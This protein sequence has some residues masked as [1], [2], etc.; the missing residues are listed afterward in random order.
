MFG[1]FLVTY[2]F[3]AYYLIDATYHL[4]FIIS[5]TEMHSIK[6]QLA[7]CRQEL[8][9]QDQTISGLREQ[10]TKVEDQKAKLEDQVDSQHYQCVKLENTVRSVS[11]EVSGGWGIWGI[12]EFGES[13]I[14]ELVELGTLGNFR[15]FG[16][17]EIR[18]FVELGSWGMS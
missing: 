18:E 8:K 5:Q 7:V 3:L 15:E 9:D 4:N 1:L 16:E 10:K 2:Y 6:T 12:K 13:E 11:E 14:R 17:L